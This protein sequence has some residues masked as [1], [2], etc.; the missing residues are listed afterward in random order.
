MQDK[1]LNVLWPQ[2]ILIPE[3]LAALNRRVVDA[4][5]MIANT[6]D[7][8]VTVL[9]ACNAIGESMIWAFSSGSDSRMSADRCVNEILNA[10]QQAMDRFLDQTRA[11]I[12]PRP[13][14]VPRL[15]KGS[16]E[17]VLHEQSHKVG[18]DVVVLGTVARTGLS[19][20]F[21]GNTAE[22][23]INSLEC[24]VLAVKPDGFVSPLLRG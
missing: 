18:A 21:I 20:V 8:E 1:T 15:S 9:H 17:I 14:L 12:G 3:T 10:R 2:S 11:E 22:D 23:I 16:P 4:A 6:P 13:R 19:G 7:A 24:P 5:C